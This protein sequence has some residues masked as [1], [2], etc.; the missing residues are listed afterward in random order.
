MS[1]C[2]I[3]PLMIAREFARV[4]AAHPLASFTPAG[5][6]NTMITIE[7]DNFIADWLIPN[8]YLT[9]SM[10]DFIQIMLNEYE[11]QSRKIAK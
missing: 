3:T 2:L 5:P 11:N 10:D 8:T 7:T 6:T 4:G 9:L 1:E